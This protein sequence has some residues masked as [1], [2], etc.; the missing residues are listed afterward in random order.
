MF[1]DV[2]GQVITWIP[3]VLNLLNFLPSDYGVRTSVPVKCFSNRSRI[4]LSLVKPRGD[5]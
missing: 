4:V 1:A 5:S 3:H 2:P